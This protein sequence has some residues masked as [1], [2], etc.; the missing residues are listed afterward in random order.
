LGFLHYGVFLSVVSFA[1]CLPEIYQNL[2]FCSPSY[3]L[4]D[5]YPLLSYQWEFGREEGRL[6]HMY[7]VGYLEPE[8]LIKVIGGFSVILSCS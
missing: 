5:L 1:V 2:V 4:R 7:S 6:K 3:L 8:D